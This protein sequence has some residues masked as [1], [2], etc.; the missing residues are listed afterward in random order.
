[1]RTPLVMDV[2]FSAC[3]FLGAKFNAELEVIRKSWMIYYG[4]VQR[5]FLRR[6]GMR[7]EKHGKYIMMIC[8]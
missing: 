1:M 2:K 5:S 8:R 3:F 4:M 6:K 7:P